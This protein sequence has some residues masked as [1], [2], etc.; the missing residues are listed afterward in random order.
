MSQSSKYEN[1][2]KSYIKCIKKYR[3]FGNNVKFSLFLLKNTLQ[4]RNNMLK[5]NHGKGNI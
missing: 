3:I 1:K 5:L 2:N 4:F